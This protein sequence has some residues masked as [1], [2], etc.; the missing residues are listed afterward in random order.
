ML[1]SAEQKFKEIYFPVKLNNGTARRI[2]KYSD[3]WNRENFIQHDFYSPKINDDD[4]NKNIQLPYLRSQIEAI[5]KQNKNPRQAGDLL[6]AILA[7]LFGNGTTTTPA[8]SDSGS[9]SGSGSAT[10]ED[11]SRATLSNRTRRPTKYPI[12]GY[13]K[14]PPKKHLREN[15]SG[16]DKSGENKSGEKDKNGSGEKDKNGSKEKVGKKH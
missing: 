5:A 2:I 12:K 14:K 13:C 16:E 6:Q 3:Q 7:F 11:P 9:G 10:T 15:D 4:D 1:L 8:P